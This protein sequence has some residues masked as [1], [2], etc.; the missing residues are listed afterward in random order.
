MVGENVNPNSIA[1]LSGAA[2]ISGVAV[3]GMTPTVSAASAIEGTMTATA[4]VAKTANVA[5][6]TRR[7][8][9]VEWRGWTTAAASWSVVIAAPYRFLERSA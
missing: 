9:P 8:A 6:A 4:T 5:T 3:S 2:S 1:D 7:R